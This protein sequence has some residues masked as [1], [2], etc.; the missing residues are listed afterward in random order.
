[1]HQHAAAPP[2]ITPGAPAEDEV[3]SAPM[4]RLMHSGAVDTA[5]RKQPPLKGISSE[6]RH[7]LLAVPAVPLAG[8]ALE[9]DV[10]APA[11][12]SALD[13][14]SQVWPAD[15]PNRPSTVLHICM[16]PEGACVDFAM[17][18]GGAAAWVHVVS[19]RQA[20][21]LVPPLPHNLAAYA[22][23]AAGPKHSGVSGIACLVAGGAT[24]PWHVGALV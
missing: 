17:P 23:W 13:L 3:D 20:V 21:A 11:A 8:T 16:E 2:S 7:R 4:H 5:A 12:V 6:A 14:V 24:G 19:G 15:A 1:V 22:A 10:T 9:G 18:P